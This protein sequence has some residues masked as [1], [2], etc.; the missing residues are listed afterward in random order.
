MSLRDKCKLYFS[1]NRNLKTNFLNIEYLKRGNK[2][3][4]Y[5]YHL[6]RELD[7][8]S[9]LS[10]HDPILVGTIP[11]GID[12]PSSDLD[13]ICNAPDLLSI[14]DTVNMAFSLHHAFSDY[15]KEEAYVASFEYKNMAIEIFA[16]AIPSTSQYGYRHMIVEGRI[17][18]LMGT[19]F[20][21]QI[22]YLK[23][24][25]EKTELAFGKLLNMNN[26][27]L[28]LLDLE[29]LSDSELKEYIHHKIYSNKR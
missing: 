23:T 13:I 6:L 27:Y 7:I 14:R 8:F 20:R 15:L 12:I 3:Q 17:L 1:K 2:R 26:A 5:I 4:I 22:I 29:N 9:I 10:Q 18:E 11:I 24:N 21:K 25:G 28:E 19:D 16:Q